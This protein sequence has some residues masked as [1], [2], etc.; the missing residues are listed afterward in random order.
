[1]M[2]GCSAGGS[3]RFDRHGEISIAAAVRSGAANLSLTDAV[4]MSA[5]PIRGL[6]GGRQRRLKI[7]SNSILSNLMKNRISFASILSKTLPSSPTTAST[8]SATV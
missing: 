7:E 6:D 4:T 3:S 8:L 2:V 1:M 5:A